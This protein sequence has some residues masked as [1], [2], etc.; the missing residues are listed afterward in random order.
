MIKIEE[1][2]T[3][4]EYYEIQKFYFYKKKKMMWYVVFV[5]VCGIL[6]IIADLVFRQTITWG[7][8]IML[9]LAACSVMMTNSR[10]KKVVNTM[11]DMD[12][13]EWEITVSHEKLT[14]KAKRMTVPMTLKASQLR[15]AYELKN[16]ILVYFAKEQFVTISK[17]TLTKDEL[18]ELKGILYDILDKKFK[19]KAEKNG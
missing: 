17:A 18:K 2:I 1:N 12:I 3:K 13:K 8:V 4:D 10:I 5:A 14:M 19:F 15:C 7:G 11:Y 6:A 9:A 16:V